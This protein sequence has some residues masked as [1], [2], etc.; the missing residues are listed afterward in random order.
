MVQEGCAALETTGDVGSDVEG[1]GTEALTGAVLA[2]V[3][4][5]WA[6]EGALAVQAQEG[7]GRAPSVLQREELAMAPSVLLQGEVKVLAEEPWLVSIFG[8]F[9]CRR[10]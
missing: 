9:E 4:E 5:A 3:L 1:L 6:L 7:S 10:W 2:L 8:L